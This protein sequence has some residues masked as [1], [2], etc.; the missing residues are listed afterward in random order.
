MNTQNKGLLSAALVLVLTVFGRTADQPATNATAPPAPPIFVAINQDIAFPTPNALRF[1]LAQGN[2]LTFQGDVYTGGFGIQG[3]FFGTSRVNSVPSVSAPC[4]YVSDS[5]SN[6]IA[7]IS[8]PTQELV[9]NFSG[10]QSDDGS[11]NGIGLAVN[12]NYLFAS[13]SSSQ[14]IG[15][16]AVQGGCGLAFLGDVPAA[17]LQGG[18]V[19]GMAVHGNILVVAYG[20]GSIQSFNVAGGLPVSNNDLQ[21]STAFT[22]V[23][24]SGL[25]TILPTGVD[26]SQDGHFAIFGETSPFVV[27]ET[28]DLTAGKLAKTVVRSYPAL[29]GV[30]TS[31]V[32]LSPDQRLLYALNSESGTVMAFFFNPASGGLVKG[33]TSPPLLGFNGRPWYGSVA[34]RDTTGTGGVLYVAEFGRDAKEIDSGPPSAVGILAVTATR[35]SC[36][37]TEVSGSPV[38]LNFPGALS[39]GV[40]PPRPF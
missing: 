20:D 23:T 19:T 2:Q 6:D 4:I 32:R 1:F 14:T 18:S 37:L 10:S 24:L 33:C 40:Y 11:S 15:T 28:S 8:L 13:F 31:T 21:N 35:T 27:L 9:G 38:L 5:G 22:T 25:G 7:S 3:G 34:T 26:I 30:D 16:F 17:G 36:T 12:A 39:L 29:T